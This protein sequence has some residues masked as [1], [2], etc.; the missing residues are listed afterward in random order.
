MSRTVTT[1]P[2]AWQTW[3][4]SLGARPMLCTSS[5]KSFGGGSSIAFIA[6]W[7]RKRPAD[8]IASPEST[9]RAALLV[10]DYCD[11]TVSAARG[12]R[13]EDLLRSGD[14]ARLVYVE[15][16][17]FAWRLREPIAPAVGRLNFW[18]EPSLRRNWRNWKTGFTGTMHS[19]RRSRSCRRRKPCDRKPCDPASLIGPG[20]SSPSRTCFRLLLAWTAPRRGNVAP[21]EFSDSSARPGM[22]WTTRRARCSCC[23]R[24]C[25]ER[26]L[27]SLWPSF[28]FPVGTNRGTGR[29]VHRQWTITIQRRVPIL[30][31]SHPTVG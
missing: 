10:S 5:S 21:G 24:P 30:V 3:H 1:A 2:I 15:Y 18:T 11:G 19:A 13:L 23:W 7:P 25:W 14:A 31:R 29:A 17:A 8:G 27:S 26:I 22:R 16:T 12:N 28:H 4:G 20:S 9:R 6:C